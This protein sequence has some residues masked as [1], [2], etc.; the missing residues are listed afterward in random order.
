[1]KS[2]SKQT[3]NTTNT[4]GSVTPTNTADMQAYRDAIGGTFDKT[5]PTIPYVFNQA[6]NNA[7][8]RFDDPFGHEVSPEVR[9]AYMH[10]T[11][12]N[13]DQAQG[14]AIREDSSNRRFGKLQ[15]LQNLASMT[16]PQIVQTGGSSTGTTVQ[17]QPILPALL[18]LGGQLGGAAMM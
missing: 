15:A 9:G 12:N 2:K 17:S 6:R 13:I 5:D 3:Q 14:Q 7:K 10:E 11:M 16:A 1:M 8:N 4:W 18:Q